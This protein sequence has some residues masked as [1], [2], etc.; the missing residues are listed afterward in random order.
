MAAKNPK[1]D[2]FEMIGD[3]CG[4]GAVLVLIFATLDKM[5]SKDGLT[6]HGALDVLGVSFFFLVTGMA[7]ERWRRI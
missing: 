3:F 1:K 4:E 2:Y 5:I 6:W 7:F